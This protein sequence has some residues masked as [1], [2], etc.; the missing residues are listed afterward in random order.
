MKRRHF[1]Q[2][3]LSLL[4]TTRLMAQRT[5]LDCDI[6]VAGGGVGG[7]AAALA[8]SATECAWLRKKPIGSEDN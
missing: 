8:G 1:L 7:F 3:S 4:A 5:E 6:V 2:G